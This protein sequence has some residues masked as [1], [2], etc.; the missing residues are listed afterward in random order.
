MPPTH[1]LASLQQQTVFSQGS[2][3][4]TELLKRDIYKLFPKREGVTYYLPVME[5]VA[6]Y[7]D[8][9]NGQSCL[10]SPAYTLASGNSRKR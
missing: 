3:G 4:L 10:L 2:L 7:T 1:P 6:L 5:T 8:I 9:P